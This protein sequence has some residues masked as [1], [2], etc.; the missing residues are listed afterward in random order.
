MITYTIDACAIIALLYDEHGSNLVG[1]IF[2]QATN[3]EAILIM[4][5][6]NLLEVFNII[7]R[8][9]GI[10]YA[11]EIYEDLLQSP[12]QFFDTLTMPFFIEFANVRKQYKIHFTD[13]FIVVTNLIHGHKGTILTS[14]HYF[15]EIK[16]HIPI[17][18][19]R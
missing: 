4:H 12:I 13:A 18:Y 1:E 11:I 10:Q 5:K 15:D 19:F 8:R 9:E 14:D 7:S 6:V 3:N 16:N 17:L 2:E